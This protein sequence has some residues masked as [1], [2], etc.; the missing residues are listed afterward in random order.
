MINLVT[1]S[2]EHPIAIMEE[3]YDRMVNLK[4][5]GWSHC[6]SQNEWLAKLHY[7]R[8]GFKEGNISQESFQSK[9]AELVLNWWK[10]WC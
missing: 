9:E 6:E 5:R 2:P 3:E 10:R 4:D 7:L 1:L 8:K